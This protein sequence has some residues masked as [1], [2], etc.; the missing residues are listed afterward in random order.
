MERKKRKSHYKA[1]ISDYD[2]FALVK[3]GADKRRV[4]PLSL[5]LAGDR[6][7][8]I[9]FESPHPYRRKDQKVRDLTVWAIDQVWNF[10]DELINLKSTPLAKDN[11][12]IKITLDVTKMMD[13]G[14]M[15]GSNRLEKRKSFTNS[16][17]K[18]GDLTATAYNTKKKIERDDVAAIT[19]WFFQGLKVIGDHREIEIN[20]NKRYAQLL[21]EGELANVGAY[22][23]HER[24]S[25][26]LMRFLN[27]HKVRGERKNGLPLYI[28]QIPLDEISEEVFGEVELLRSEFSTRQT[29]TRMLQKLN[30]SGDLPPYKIELKHNRI[31]VDQELLSTQVIEAKKRR[32]NVE[33]K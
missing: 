10:N 33:K 21:M 16:V 8:C 14:E 1:K 13:F 11:E 9:K 6:G 3:G 24:K 32:K 25:F 4:D 28:D 31:I 20:I 30:E 26:D 5:V 27:I 22:I 12:V 7:F 17:R 29:L 15:Y 19:M 23:R 2:V 18:L